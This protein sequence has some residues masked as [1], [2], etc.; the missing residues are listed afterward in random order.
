MS[1]PNDEGNSVVSR[2]LSAI[3]K[4]REG[5]TGPGQA[6]SQDEAAPTEHS[7]Q[8]EQLSQEE[9]GRDTPTAPVDDST[10]I[11]ATESETPAA[12][13]VTEED[14]TAEPSDD[15]TSEAPAE[16]PSAAD[17]PEPTSD[18]DVP[19][20]EE[21]RVDEDAL[22][23]E[24]P[25][26]DED[27]SV[28]ENPGVDEGP[29][30]D[31]EAGVDEEAGGDPA[32]AEAP[33][34]A[35]APVA[36]EASSPES[37]P[38][39]ES[40]TEQAPAEPSPA[41]LAADEAVDDTAETESIATADSEAD[42]VAIVAGD[43]GVPGDDNETADFAAV[44]PVGLQKTSS[45]D[46]QPPA[47]GSPA[48][49]SETQV[50]ATDSAAPTEVID[51]QTERIDVTKASRPQERP[52]QA[53]GWKAEPSTPQ[54]IAPGGTPQDRPSGVPP[55]KSRK[56]IWIGLAALIVIIGVV[57]A[58]I[59]VV[60]ANKE[61]SVPAAD[62]AADTA[63]E[64]TAALRDGDIVVLRSITCGEA[65]ARFAGISDEE[66]AEDHRIQEANNELVGVDGVKASKIVEDGNSAVVE[67]IA[68]KTATPDQKLD[69]ALTLSKIDG[70]WKVC[71]A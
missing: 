38:A 27:P 29:V 36:T 44:P 37:S 2:A 3:R 42:T 10:D 32:P 28:D 54:Y 57:A 51:A 67:V 23:D 19:S 6:S 21:A 41:E 18:E 62:V 64:Y 49:E 56:G 31:E 68:F 5:K 16:S 60:A 30:I 7:P 26:V 63:L 46:P 22:V 65:Q 25:V 40:P 69:V 61:E 17:A 71:K 43:T 20:D 58:V 14:S 35:A 33:E 34:T 55:K 66:F 13:D 45:A 50:I 52:A 53:T 59:G 1:H 9:P 8:G 12:A 47:V 39:E 70:E 48:D 24:E 4:R 15:P 11:P